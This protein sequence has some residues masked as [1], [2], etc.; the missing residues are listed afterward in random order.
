[1]RMRVS[2]SLLCGIVVLVVSATRADDS[3]DARAIIDK[4]IKASGGEEKLAK[5]KAE[6]FKE[7]G[8]YYGMGNGQP[9]QGTYQV[10]LP[11]QFKMEIAGVFILVVDGDKGWMKANGNTMDLT[12]EQL[13]EHKNSNYSSWVASL[14]PL[15]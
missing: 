8:T 2:V 7:K 9:Y 4:A 14:L 10:Q 12:K 5:Y 13:A 3:A 6:T 15:K 11:D 1:M